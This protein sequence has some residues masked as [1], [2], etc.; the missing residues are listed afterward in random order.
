MMNLML[1]CIASLLFFLSIYSQDVVTYSSFSPHTFLIDNDKLNN[2]ILDQ[3][4]FKI[5][6]LSCGSGFLISSDGY[7]LTAG[8][9][10]EGNPNMIAIFKDN[11]R[12]KITLIKKSLSSDSLDIALIKLEGND[13]KYLPLALLDEIEVANKVYAIGTPSVIINTPSEG[14]VMGKFNE[15]RTIYLQTTVRVDEGN[16]GGPLLGI[17]KNKVYG[18]VTSKK[19]G[20]EGAVNISIPSEVAI[21][22]FNIKEQKNGSDIPKNLVKFDSTLTIRVL[23]DSYPVSFIGAF[24]GGFVNGEYKEYLSG[25]R[26]F[27]SAVTEKTI[28]IDKDCSHILIN[29][30]LNRSR[31]LLEP[32]D[33]KNLLAIGHHLEIN[34]QVI[35]DN[36]YIYNFDSTSA[37]F[38]I[39][40]EQINNKENSIDKNTF[41]ISYSTGTG[42]IFLPKGA[43]YFILY[44]RTGEYEKP[45]NVEYLID[46]N[47]NPVFWIDRETFI[48]NLGEYINIAIE[49]NKQLIITAD[50]GDGKNHLIMNNFIK[51]GKTKNDLKYLERVQNI[52]ENWSGEVTGLL[53]Y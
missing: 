46:R 8:H 14:I 47:E 40:L 12:K 49:K 7:A 32:P 39:N 1:S 52:Q 31:W 44:L 20:W 28:K 9:I 5:D 19:F 27:T 29:C 38:E 41:P 3:C 13:Y 21:K 26:E 30:K 25:N 17:N 10:V 22:Y 43:K 34:N 33:K 35:P 50:N 37:N 18:I 4:V 42:Y 48:K 16:S 24:A 36:S 6:G 53:E 11:T 2:S 45:N 23:K 15:N 51:W